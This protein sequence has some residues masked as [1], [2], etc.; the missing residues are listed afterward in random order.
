VRGSLKS[1]T[2]RLTDKADLSDNEATI[3]DFYDDL[4]KEFVDESVGPA[5]DLAVDLIQY[6]DYQAYLDSINGPGSDFSNTTRELRDRAIQER[7][8]EAAQSSNIIERQLAEYFLE[9]LVEKLDREYEEAAAEQEDPQESENPE[10]SEVPE[11]AS[12][13][14]RDSAGGF[15]GVTLAIRTQFKTSHW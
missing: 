3:V 2:D 4:A 5:K 12:G 14:K 11:E 15:L 9:E 13:Q 8:E 7:L 1:T 6:Y 10:E